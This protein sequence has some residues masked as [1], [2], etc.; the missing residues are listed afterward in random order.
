MKMNFPII[1]KL[2]GVFRVQEKMKKNEYEISS[3]G[4]AM[5]KTRRVIPGPAVICLMQIAE[6]EGIETTSN[7]FTLQ[8]RPDSD[9]TGI[10]R[11]IAT[12]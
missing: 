5:W 6:G 8:G 9:Q 1:D 7:D 4:I 3:T 10:N 11:T 2:G 12:R